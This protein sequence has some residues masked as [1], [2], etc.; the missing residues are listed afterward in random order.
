VSVRL[1]LASGSPRRRQILEVLGLDFD[2]VDPAVDEMRFPDEEPHDY[3]ERVARAKAAAVV[4]PARVVLAADTA[5]IIEGHLL[6]KPSHPE[7]AK[8][9]LRRLSGK[10]HEVLTGVALARTGDHQ[11]V[12]SEVSSTLVRFLPLTEEEIA[13]YVEGGE[14]MDKAGAYALN[15][16]GAIFVESVTGS[17]S[18]VVGLP[19]HLTARLFRTAGLDLLSF[20]HP[21]EPAWQE[22]LSASLPIESE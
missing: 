11:E 3:V 19:L 4:G 5:V 22:P 14:P 8:S 6:G 18:G 1:V 21:L 9:M 12:W 10:T 17:P 16:R 20:T 15:G 13:E 7:E 2:T